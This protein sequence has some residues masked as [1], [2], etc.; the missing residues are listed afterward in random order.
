MNALATDGATDL[1]AGVPPVS[2]FCA[3]SVR[4]IG[5]TAVVVVADGSGA[6]RALSLM[7]DELNRLDAT[8]SRFRADSE[9]RRLE[10]ASHGRPMPVSH[11]LTHALTVACEAAERSGGT[12]DPTVGAALVES[13][14]D[15]DFD[16][17]VDDATDPVLGAPAPGWWRL[18]V[19]EAAGT[20]AVPEGI[21]I[22]LGATGKALVADL[23]ARRVAAE[24]GVGVLV[25]VGGDV[26]VA[27][28]APTQGWPVGIAARSTTPGDDVDV[29]LSLRSGAV[30]TSGT[31][32]RA[33][34]R[35]GRPMHH[36]FDPWT[37][38][39][40]EPVWSYVSALAPTCVEANT[41]STAAIVWGADA[42]GNLAAHGVSARLVGADGRVEVVG[43]WPMEPDGRAGPVT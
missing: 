24:L 9:I 31:R 40:A 38:E 7:V 2:D 17:I 26:G 35:N 42:P 3:R 30:A 43:A 10:R 15:R 19:D 20:A 37:G 1:E 39:P 14:Y 25:N 29:V 5:T 33:W 13:G 11:L 4:A 27:G 18:H 16:A 8:C 23:S 12:V 22:D 36:I 28:P 6:D 41:W 32:S 34:T 21:H